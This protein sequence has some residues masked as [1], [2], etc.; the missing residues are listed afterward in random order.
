ME[1]IKKDIFKDGKI[2]Y[3]DTS[4]ETADDTLNAE[5]LQKMLVI[6]EQEKSYQSKEMK[7]SIENEIIQYIQKIN[8]PE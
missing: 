6:I 7:T 5:Y 1:E 4:T 8:I 3:I 2:D